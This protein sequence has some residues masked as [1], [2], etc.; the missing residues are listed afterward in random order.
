MA[1]FD[2]NF[3]AF[4]NHPFIENTDNP[5]FVSSIF[6]RVKS[7][8]SA[9][10]HVVNN[11]LPIPGS[12]SLSNSE[13][14][15][16]IAAGAK[17]PSLGRLSSPHSL[18]NL[19]ITR[20]NS[21][22]SRRSFKSETPSRAVNALSL[23]LAKSH[24]RTGL[25]ESPEIGTSPFSSTNDTPNS[26]YSSGVVNEVDTSKSSSSMPVINVSKNIHIN[27]SH[28]P[29]TPIGEFPAKAAS[30]LLPSDTSV[31]NNNITTF[32]EPTIPFSQTKSTK[33][34]AKQKTESNGELRIA[35]MTN[36]KSDSN[37]RNPYPDS[38]LPHNI[39]SLFLPQTRSAYSSLPVTQLT[40]DEVVGKNL[41]PDRFKNGKNIP[42]DSIVSEKLRGV[43]GLNLSSTSSI[44]GYN[45]GSIRTD[46][47]I[48]S[49]DRSSL[50]ERENSSDA[51]SIY[52]TSVPQYFNSRVDRRP[53]PLK[54][55][56]LGK[57][58]WMKD[59]HATECF[60]CTAKFTSKKI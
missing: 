52:S 32:Y 48:H 40:P 30:M 33:V 17:V 25:V 38:Q 53:A 49:R 19:P 57:E 26:R 28:T 58:Y 43:T 22:G 59:E 9:A 4:P 45:N 41:P 13:D 46:S 20:P 42:K 7:I 35:E 51:E 47:S 6:S 10:S 15:I 24:S 34:D 2:D 44:T 36:P 37:I 31:T 60:G 12:D 29:L 3:T 56:G 55:G 23:A 21:S 27:N 18:V 5:N 8:T 14:N 39:P 50:M 54:N 11:V 1:E 16:V